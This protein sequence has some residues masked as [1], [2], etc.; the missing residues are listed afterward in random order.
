MRACLCARVRAR[1]RARRAATGMGVGAARTARGRGRVRVHTPARVRTRARVRVCVEIGT[2]KKVQVPS[3]G[4]PQTR[5]NR[6]G[7]A[8]VEASVILQACPSPNA[9]HAVKAVSNRSLWRPLRA[10]VWKSFSICTDLA[11]ICGPLPGTGQPSP[12]SLAHCGAAPGLTSQQLGA[13]AQLLLADALSGTE[14]KRDDAS[15]QIC[16]DTSDPPTQAL[17]TQW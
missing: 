7:E 1:A 15:H 12:M 9:G 10:M 4:S 2:P 6:F 13:L 14:P 11:V 17:S 5:C 16:D 8:T 3:K